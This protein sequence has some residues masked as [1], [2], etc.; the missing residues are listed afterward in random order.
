MPMNL[1]LVIFELVVMLLSISLHD[2]AQAWM[3]NKL[4]DPTARLLG[5]QTIN[6]VPHFDFFGMALWPLIY[7]WRSPLILGW[8]KPIPM[9]TRNFRQPKDEIKA[10]LAGPV[11]QFVAAIV[12]L[13]ALLVVKHANPTAGGTLGIAAELSLRNLDVPTPATP[14]FPLILFFYFGILVN[15]LLCVF[16]LVPLPF[17]DGGKILVYYLPYNAARAYERWGL[18]LM[19]G[20]MFFGFGIVLAVFL[21]LLGWFNSVLFAL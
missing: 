3:A 4:G 9:T 17:L 8:G 19:F 15:L 1:A 21:P 11:A 14:L 20:F 5:R 6:P 12:C 13:L 7:I 2:C 10:T 18:W 16:N